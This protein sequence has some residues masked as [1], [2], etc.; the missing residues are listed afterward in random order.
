MGSAFAIGPALAPY[1]LSWFGYQAGA[2]GMR[3]EQPQSAIIAIYIGAGLT[4][5]ALYGLSLIFLFR[6][7]LSED[8]LKALRR[9]SPGFIPGTS[10]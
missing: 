6:H 1:F 2:E 7:D 5:A 8:R 4:P 10:G 9:R 3:I